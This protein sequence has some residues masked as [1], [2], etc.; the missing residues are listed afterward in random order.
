MARLLVWNENGLLQP[1]EVG[2][3]LN[4]LV[5]QCLFHGRTPVGDGGILSQMN[6][7]IKLIIYC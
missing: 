2:K 3:Q 6:L 1:D 7:K 4:E 5:G